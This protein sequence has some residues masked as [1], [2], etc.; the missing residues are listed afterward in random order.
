MQKAFLLAT[1]AS[2]SCATA[3]PATTV[4]YSLWAFAWPPPRTEQCTLKAGFT[5]PRADFHQWDGS[6]DLTFR[7]V[8]RRSELTHAFDTTVYHQELRVERASR[9]GWW[10][11][12]LLQPIRDTIE[13]REEGRSL[14]NGAPNF[15]GEW[16]C[17]VRFPFVDD[18]TTS[19]VG[20]VQLYP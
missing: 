19:P 5:V 11:L 12:V 3:R 9:D 2:L 20:L 4:R 18:S 7:R 10:R 8:V 6:A 17:G 1:L 14:A 13:L 16:R 15:T